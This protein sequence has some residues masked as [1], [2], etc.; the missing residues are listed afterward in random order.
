MSVSIGVTL[1]THIIDR[2]V[3]LW[4]GSIIQSPLTIGGMKA[5]GF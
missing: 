5:V 3:A 1:I 4:P 2:S